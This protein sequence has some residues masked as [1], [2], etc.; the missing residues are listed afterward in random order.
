[1]DFRVRC[2]QLGQARLP[3]KYP[4]DSPGPGLVTKVLTPCG[5]S[6]KSLITLLLQR[7]PFASRLSH[8]PF[9]LCRLQPE[10]ADVG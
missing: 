7:S 2:L 3:A 8:N 9:V 6:P 5:Y 1:M 4:R 10:V